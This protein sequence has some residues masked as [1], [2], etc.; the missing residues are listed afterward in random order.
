MWGDFT[1]HT[2]A[3]SLLSLYLIPIN[4]KTSRVVYMRRQAKRQTGPYSAILS[5]SQG[6]SCRVGAFRN[7]IIRRATLD[8]RQ[9]WRSGC[10]PVVIHCNVRLAERGSQRVRST[11]TA[12]RGSDAH[13]TYV[14]G[15]DHDSSNKNLHKNPTQTPMA[16]LYRRS[17]K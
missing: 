11:H 1:Q 15:L 17:Y 2:R 13:G 3:L 10:V 6:A 4:I 14:L 7:M 9:S 5:E 16:T 8:P 12:S